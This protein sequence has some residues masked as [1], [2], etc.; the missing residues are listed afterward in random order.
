[1]A[2][3]T[4]LTAAR[5]L[6]IEAASVVDGDIVGDDL[7]LTKKDGSVINAGN[8]RG[9]PGPD[10]PM[11][12]PLSVISAQPVLDVGIPNQIRAGRQLSPADFTNMGLSAPLALWNLSNLL[13]SSGAGRNLSNKG[14]VPFVSGINGLATTAAQ[15]AGSA[16]QALYLPDA[17]SADP[18][19]VRTGSFGC[20]I[21]TGRR[22]VVQ[23][24]F[25]KLD[26]VGA[27]MSWGF[28]VTAGNVILAQISTNGTPTAPSY[29]TVTGTTDVADNRWHFILMTVDGSRLRLYVDGVLEG[30]PAA[31]NGTLFGSTAPINVGGRFADAATGASNPFFGAVDEAFVSS[32]ILSDEQVRNLYCASIPHALGSVPTMMSVSLRRRRRGGP[33]AV[34]DFPAQPV[35]LY[36]FTGGVLTD[37][38]SNNVPLAA[39]AGGS[40]VDVVGAAG[41]SSGAKAFSGAHAGLMSTDAG[42]PSGLASRSFGLWFKT[43][44]GTVV[45]ML[46]WGSG[47]SSAAGVWLGLATTGGVAL[48]DQSGAVGSDITGP[49][50]VDGVWHH[51]VVVEDNAPTDGAK[52]KMYLDGKLVGV[53]TTLASVVLGGANRFRI[54]A[55]A[56]GTSPFVGMLDAPFVFAGA[57]T[58]EQVRAL[59]AV[60]SQQMAASPKNEGDFVK[61]METARLLATFDAVETVDTVN[62]AVM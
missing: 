21:R 53:S 57:L 31:V 23:E 29:A 15:F 59:Y 16:G 20:W 62:L 54:G 25:T 6:A 7:F 48:F 24:P 35:R 55:N 50:V 61:T 37:Q 58:A 34:T 8:V 13:D 49:N 17:G 18:M 22:G 19:R 39:S 4:G 1:M 27:Q 47:A 10:G 42:L 56:D 60:G 14:A 12:H 5:M 2:T 44:G 38:G 51:A 45:G 46:S 28:Q 30:A 43:N 36:N 40:I 3:V 26:A 32:E 52:R 11:G 33:F 9:A 41:L